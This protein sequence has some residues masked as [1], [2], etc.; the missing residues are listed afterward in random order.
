MKKLALVGAAVL[1]SLGVLLPLASSTDRSASLVR[2][3]FEEPA[4][5]SL[6]LGEGVTV[7]GDYDEFLLAVVDG[8]G[9]SRLSRPGVTAE[10]IDRDPAA[11]DDY[12]V[13][14]VPEELPAGAAAAPGVTIVHE[15]TGHVVFRATPSDALDFAGVVEA[16]AERPIHG[17]LRRVT[18][19]S[20]APVVERPLPEA[21]LV[22]VP[23]PDVQAMV[24]QVSQLNLQNRVQ[25]LQ[26]IAL[27]NSGGRKYNSVGGQ[28]AENSIVSWLQGY[29][30]PE[31]GLVVTTQEFLSGSHDNVLA[32]LPGKVTPEEHVIVGAHYDSTCYSCT[33]PPG[34]DDNATG[35]ACV[36]EA[37]R[38][39][40]QHDFEKTI[41]FACWGAEEIGLV[42]S[43]Y[44]ATT[45]RQNGDD[46]YGYLNFD[47]NG[48]LKPGNVRTFSVCTNSSS[49][50]LIQELKD[51][52]DAYA[53]EVPWTTGVLTAGSSDHAS[54]TG[55][56]YRACFPFESFNDYSP[57]IHS[58]QDLVGLSA[59]DFL[60]IEKF[61]RLGVAAL[62]TWAA[63]FDGFA[64]RHDPLADTS[65]NMTKRPV[66]ASV[67][68]SEGVQSVELVWSNG[69]EGEVV[70]PMTA[71][72]NPDEYAATIPAHPHGVVIS[73]YLR[74]TDG[75]GTVETLP[76]T[77]P[78][79]LFS[80]TAIP[81]QIWFF[82]DMEGGANGWTHEQIA[83]QD[84]WMLGPAN[85]QGDNPYD[86]LTAWSGE[87]IW[88]NDLNPPGFQGNYADNVHNLL[89]SPSIDLSAATGTIL[90]YRR[91]LSVENG[92]YDRATLEVAGVPIW[93]NPVGSDFVDA[94]WVSHEIDVS[95]IADGKPS[96]QIVFRLQSDGY[97]TFGGWNIDDVELY[98]PADPDELFAD[99]PT[100]PLGTTIHLTVRAPE[101]PGLDYEIFASKKTTPGIDVDGDRVIPLRADGTYAKVNQL[102]ANGH[103]WVIAFEGTLD[104]NGESTEPALFIPNRERFS[105]SR[106]FFSGVVRD[107]ATVVAVLPFVEVQIQ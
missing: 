76:E 84:D 92:T 80:Y 28:V 45:A 40:S 36:L 42:G 3:T 86:P 102:K 61:V 93:Q 27:Q 53:S 104:A 106:F 19:R 50:S 72:G 66:V 98:S 87:N 15:G 79:S 77:A 52:R 34:A 33:N 43:D 67:I 65:D 22:L 54:F 39:L 103:P 21:G 55:Q 59:N 8:S 35:A 62:A 74:A 100:P 24:D 31:N 73:Y 7:V 16:E 30:T 26:D 13:L 107:G 88:G 71:T 58:D 32:I 94:G 4:R 38:I 9:W 101:G 64:I 37:C 41:I 23:D 12:Y 47:M 83:T 20:V 56:G 81:E 70:V 96:A 6:G 89:R 90:R 10:A 49:A 29:A 97:V 68:A 14:D 5:K 11:K 2:I 51:V 78:A 105:G 91:C 57:Y 82:D 17:A 46:I 48:Y 60:Q 69:G 85:Q 44:Y 18:L 25:S 63:P 95:A 1:A 99:D 75:I